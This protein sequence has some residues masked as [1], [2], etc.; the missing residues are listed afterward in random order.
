MI[1]HRGACKEKIQQNKIPNDMHG[2]PIQYIRKPKLLVQHS[3]DIKYNHAVLVHP[4]LHV[5]K[6]LADFAVRVHM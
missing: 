6:V 2:V 5:R 4:L 3:N 1:L